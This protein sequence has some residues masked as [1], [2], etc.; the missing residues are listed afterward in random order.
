M[1][2][3]QVIS[4][5]Q[6]LSSDLK[7][8]KYLTL[9]DTHKIPKL[10]YFIYLNFRNFSNALKAAGLPTSKLAAAMILTNEQLLNYLKDLKRKYN[11]KP[12]CWDF[13]DDKELFKKYSDYQISWT[14]YKT[15]FGGLREAIKLI[16]KDEVQPEEKILTL[17]KYEDL[18]DMPYSLGGKNRYW[19][20]GAELHVTAELLYRGFQAATIPVDEGLDIL[21]VKDNNTFC[22]QVKHKN[23]ATNL[24]V[25]ITKS[26]FEK[27]GR[28]TVFFIFVLLSENKRDFI[29]VPFHIV[30]DW[31]LEG[32]A[33]PTV[34]GKGYHIY[35]KA[36][37]NKY[38]LNEK[39]LNYYV[40]NWDLI[41]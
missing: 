23:I 11:R 4:N 14:I 15:R 28:G 25:E 5:L 16:E 21:A 35:I 6:K 31:I 22:F 12:K 26:S 2:K 37:D 33:T 32:F 27:T 7:T 30:N 36:K 10:E 19:G 20:K 17:D 8:K 13:V 1:D 34:T 41:K 24:P 40:N 3:E 29:I 9:E 38:L 39:D 18:E